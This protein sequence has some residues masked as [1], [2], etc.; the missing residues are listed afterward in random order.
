M[1]V[2]LGLVGLTKCYNRPV[3]P[4]DYNFAH[5]LAC[6]V[7]TSKTGEVLES[8]DAV[9]TNSRA[10][11]AEFNQGFYLAASGRGSRHTASNG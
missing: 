2:F 1:L 10:P 9:L 8:P 11:V 7:G 6:F 3:D 4:I 5:S